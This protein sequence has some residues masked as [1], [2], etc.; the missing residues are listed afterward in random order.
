LKEK[1]QIAMFPRLFN[2]LRFPTIKIIPSASFVLR[3]FGSTAPPQ[4]AEGKQKIVT[5]LYEGGEAGRRSKDILGCVQNELGL[6]GFLT[7]RGHDFVVTSDKD[8]PN[9]VFEKHL[10]DAT[11]VISQPFWPAYLTP[12]RIAKAP[13]LKLAITAGVGSDHVDLEAACKAGLT[14]AEV[15]GCNVVSVAEHVVMQILALVRNYIPAYKQVVN[16]QWDIAAIAERAWDLEGKHVGT[17]AAGRIGYRVLQRL[18]PF[19]VHLHYY[20]KFRLTPE[21]EKELNVTYHPTVESL[22]KA[23]DVLTIN[24]PLHPETERLVNADLL[25]KMKKGSYIVNTARGKIVDTDALVAAVES[26][27]IEGYAGDVWFP[28]PASRYHPWRYMPRHAMT[29]HYSGTTL[30]AQARYAAGVKEILTS[31]FDGKPQKAENMIVDRGTLVSPAYTR[32]HT[33]GGANIRTNVN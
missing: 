19:D 5:V 9:S 25:S 12:E 3:S 13:K 24:T 8:G 31:Y 10:S 2:P 18:K 20:D 17:L 26:G 7:E 11:V 32:G 22:V 16:G 6:R 29:P 15:T 33:T 21:Q 4:K 14:V 1:H 30:S 28:Q 27:H 23:V